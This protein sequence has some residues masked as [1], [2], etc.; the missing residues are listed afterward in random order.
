MGVIAGL[1][2]GLYDLAGGLLGPVTNRLPGSRVEPALNGRYSAQLN[3]SLED[4]MADLVEPLAVVVMTW[5]DGAPVFAGVVGEP[6]FDFGAGTCQVPAFGPSLRLERAFVGQR[7]DG[8]G[9][10]GA[11]AGLPYRLEQVAEGEIMWRLVQHASPTAAEQAAGVP[12]H[13]IAR[14]NIHGGNLRDREYDPG[15]QLW[16]AIT[17]LSE[18]IDGCDF[19]LRPVYDPARSGVL[20]ELDTFDRMGADLTD[21]VR[22]EFG[23]GDNTAANLILKPSGDV[24]NRMTGV[25]EAPPYDGE[26]DAPEP[27]RYTADQPASQVA[28]GLH[29]DYRG[30]T[31]I[32]NLQRVAEHVGEVVA[33]QAFPVDH[34]DVV[35]ALQD[36]SA[37]L[38][39]DDGQV[40]RVAGLGRPPRFGPGGEWWLGDSF[41]AIGRRGRRTADLSGR[42]V[43]ATIEEV[44]KAGNIQVTVHSVPRV[45]SVVSA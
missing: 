23:V 14:G 44:D 25:G 10:V 9:L 43:G 39:G 12:D 40:R 31:G 27:P 32:D 30:L 24:V 6:T 15:K 1:S 34:F 35:P 33:T 45:I 38:V 42:V 8:A 18:V 16:E 41:R 37:Y 2:W 5:L 22:L 20:A 26:G 7:S 28:Y 11:A 3:L 13:G 19:D 21:R 17:E 36:G 29:G 4:E